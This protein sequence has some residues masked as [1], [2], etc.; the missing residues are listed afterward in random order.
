MAPRGERRPAPSKAQALR[1][2]AESALER[3]AAGSKSWEKEGDLHATLARLVTRVAIVRCAEAH[4]PAGVEKVRGLDLVHR[5]RAARDEVHVDAASLA[6]A[7]AILRGAA[8]PDPYELGALHEALLGIALEGEAGRSLSVTAGGARRSAGAHY[9]PAALAK[10]VARRTI[11]PLL[12][13]DATAKDV[14]ALHVCDAAMGAGAFLLASCEVL[15]E[16][17][18]AAREREH[19]GDRRRDARGRAP[20]GARLADATRAEAKGAAL[21]DVAAA[22]LFGVDKDP[23][24]AAIGRVALWIATASEEDPATFLGRALRVGDALV[25]R[26]AGELVWPR[27]IEPFHWDAA[28]PEV[29]SEGGG[30]DAIVGNPPWI[31]YAGR[32]AQPLDEELFAFYLRTNPAFFGYR[33]LQGLFV[34]RAATLLKTGGRLGLVVPTSMSD[35]AGYAPS[36]RAH[37]AL[38]FVDEV[39]PDFGD[40]FD[41]VFQPCMGL[42]STRDATT[43]GQ[44]LARLAKKSTAAKKVAEEPKTEGRA[45]GA[46]WPLERRDLDARAE[47]LLAKLEALPKVPASMF[48]ERGYQSIGDDVQKMRA[49]EVGARDGDVGLRIGSDVAAFRRSA[50][51][52]RCDPRELSARFRAD[53]EWRAVSVLIRQT[54]RFPM[55]CVADGVP[56]RNSVLAGFATQEVPAE[57]LAA[58]LNSWPVR[59][60]HY[61]RH[62]DARQGMPQLKIAHLRALPCPRED[63][64]KREAIVEMARAWSDRNSGLQP[65]E[66]RALD[67][68]VSDLLGLDADERAIVRAWAATFA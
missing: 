5:E 15:A 51:S 42:F 11:E 8:A 49:F 7:E 29:L 28:F 66:Q 16:R 37:D 41:D 20:S 9:T 60:F 45:L 36:R 67:A 1:A 23:A 32:A 38:C 21:R 14:L 50:P 53:E 59:W 34:Y 27:G 40:R 62:R 61:V 30:F 64:A 12:S 6:D 65:E 4:H 2:A 26:P 17:L 33:N 55:A 22:C 54:A 43:V 57:M 31:S 58:Y 13:E 35:L 63:P 52:Y 47:A 3:L 48:G 25:G 56:F 10:E 24:A 68:I 39:L 19:Q 46:A 44:A 18:V